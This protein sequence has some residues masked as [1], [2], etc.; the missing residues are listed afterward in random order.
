MKIKNLLDQFTSSSTNIKIAAATAIVIW[1]AIFM[2]LIA[3]TIFILERPGETIPPTPGGSTPAIALEP[4]TGPVGTRVTVQGEGWNMGSMV[5]IY[6]VAPG[7]M[8]IPAYGVS[9]A[10]V[11]LEGRFTASFVFPSETRWEN[12]D[13]ATVIARA[14]DSGASAQALFNIVSTSQPTE[15]PGVTVE[16]TATPTDEGQRPQPG[17]PMVTAITN[18]NIRSGPGTAYP[19]LGFLLARQTAEVTGISTDAGWWQIKFSGAADDRGWLSAKYVTA[20]NTSN[21]PVV[22]APPLPA[23]PTPTPVSTPVVISDWRGVYYDNPNLSGAPVLVRNDVSVNFDWGTGSPAPGALA[24]NFSALWSR[25]LHFPA[26]TYRF[27]VRVDDGVRLWV[28]GK[29]VIDQWHDGSG[30]YTADMNLTDG[31]HDLRMEYYERGGVAL[32]QLA[33]ERLENYPDWKAEYY[34]NPNLSGA[35]ALVR[36]DVLVSFDWGTGSPGPGV[37]LDNFS[38]RWSRSLHFPAGNYRFHVRVDDG[39]RLWV[40]GKLVIDQ[41]HDSVPTTYTADVNVANGWHSVWMEYY[42]R[43]GGALAQLAWERLE[44]YSDWKAEYYNNRK[45]EGDPVLVRNETQIDYNWGSGS[46]AT[47]VPA[48]NFSARWAR[49]VDFKSGTYV[50]SVR[51]DDGVRLWVDDAL[52]IDSWQDGRSRLIQVEHQ[53]S[54]GKHWV[55]VEYYERGGDA[56]IE[57]KWQRKDQPTNQ[58]P[59]AV[60][61]GPYTVNEGG[62]VTF[63]GSGSKDPDGSIVKY[64]W[65]FDYDGRVFIVGATG[66]TASMG[67]PDGPALVT[68]ALQVT[69]DRG[70]SQIAT[71]QVTVVNVAPTVEAGGP[72]VGEVDSL[73]GMAGTA[74]D[75]G[76]VDQ[77][78][79]TY[80]WDFGDGTQGSGPIVSHSYPQAG[81]YEVKLTVTDKDGAQG[82]DTAAVQVREGNRPP[83]AI[84]S[85]PTSGLV[86]EALDFSGVNSADEDGRIVRYTWDFGDGTT[87]GGINVTHSYS[88]TGSY[89]VTLTVTDDDSLSN[90][91]TQT[92]L[93]DEPATDLPPTAVIGG[94]TRGL[95]GTTLSFSGAGSDDG[96]GRI[97]SYDWDLGDGAVGSGVIVTHVYTAA[98]SYQVTLAVTDDGGLSDSAMQTVWVDE[99][100]T[101]LLP[102]A[103]ISGPVIGL[104]GETLSFSGTDSVDDD[105]R[106][107]SYT[108]D[109]SDGITGSGITVTHSYSPAG[110]YTVTLTVTDDGGLSDS[111]TQAVQIAEITRK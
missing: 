57:V 102:T 106:L 94:P 63:D 50:F 86:G 105:G 51:V 90:S 10:V 64:E 3:G 18:L 29:L 17:Q 93:V 54:S 104:V 111:A 84:I 4:T 41:W 34:N 55:K 96:D 68:I 49:R 27:R 91:A 80:R 65:D 59:Q 71:T 62:L 110:S 70:A 97:V 53:L 7:E 98:G 30:I 19:V 20:Q 56:Q 82:T 66:R 100:V 85:G 6:L 69:D 79:L 2:A 25:S 26:G 108:W 92:V 37:P 23:T 45:L 101:N 13:R 95:V 77:T 38:A 47:G 22:Q 52:V 73:I 16:P 74:V 99:L 75:P 78:G 46:P 11:D 61:G 8:E 109:L 1:V 60:P 44:D 103:V 76:F 5:L 67:Y 89:T 28:D 72:Y 15:T 88:P 43:G 107:V 31:L 9:G 21:V 40:D 81:N 12:Q 48:D 33:W 83:A 35:P 42:E 58:A 14:A 36:N 24:D 32:A 87:G 39:A